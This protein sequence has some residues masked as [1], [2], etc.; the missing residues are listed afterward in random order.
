MTGNKAGSKIKIDHMAKIYGHASLE[1]KIRGRQVKKAQINVF[2]SSRFF[3]HLVKGK[4]FEEARRLT[5][6][7]CGICAASHNITSIMAAENAAG[8]E[9]DEQ[10]KRLREVLILGGWIQSHALHAYFLALPDYMGHG[11]II[12][13]A[14]E[15][16]EEVERAFRLKKLG[17]DIIE[18]IGGRAT[19]PVTTN[20]GRFTNIPESGRIKEI[21]KS[22]ETGIKDALKTVKLFSSFKIPEFSRERPLGS[23]SDGKNY[24]IL[25][26]EPLIAGDRVNSR[27]FA[28]KVKLESR[29]YSTSKFLSYRG[30][31][32]LTGPLARISI[33]HRH[34]SPKARTA[35]KRSGLHLPDYN[36][37]NAN[38]ARVV[39]MVHCVERCYDAIKKIKTYTEPE[40]FDFRK[41]SGGKRTGCAITEAPRGMLYHEYTIDRNLF[42][43]GSNIITP[44]AQNLNPMENDVKSF[45][46]G[47]LGKPKG[48]IINE[49]EKLIR[50]FDPCISCATH[51]LDVRLTEV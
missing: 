34:L 44:T 11:S 45:L 15:H 18:A 3:E 27:D 17:N 9:P 25:S 7:I 2:E 50:S 31:E 1:V 49:L 47:V 23:L 16:R 19:H 30:K 20:V 5:P 14:G 37:F 26:G 22:L 40:A 32:Y 21:K 51:F 38:L 29:P 33:N 13:M 4:R 8:I 46:P 42:I 43:T 36:P 41:L 39:E 35:L 48:V 24:S 28:K 12:D 6:R 10:V